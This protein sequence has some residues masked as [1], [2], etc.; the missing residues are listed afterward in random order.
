VRP[1][2]GAFLLLLATAAASRGAGPPAQSPD[3][4]QST[5]LDQGAGRAAVAAARQAAPDQ[6]YYEFE[7]Q[8]RPRRGDVRSIPGRLWAGRDDRGPVLRLVLD[9]GAPDECRWLIQGGAEPAAWRGAAGAPAQSADL[10]EPLFPGVEITAFDLQMPFLYW[11]D[12]TLLSV[13]R[14]M[15]RPTYVMLF[16]PPAAFAGRH[17]GV[18]TVRGYFD[19]QFKEPRQFEVWGAAANL[20]TV[21][22]NDVKLDP[23]IV[24]EVD[25]RNENTRDTTRFEVMAAAVGL[26]LLPGIFTPAELGADVAPPAGHLLVRL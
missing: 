24:K 9:P 23:P 17:P 21:T 25:F 11:P 18:A 1:A 12:S 26:E 10:L 4:V 2:A 20:R 7:L 3:Y 22:V 13:T 6:C 16:R 15:G 8:I 5:G 19:T 14:L